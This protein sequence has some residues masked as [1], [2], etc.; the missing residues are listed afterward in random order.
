MLL[1]TMK[2]HNKVHTNTFGNIIQM[3]L[4]FTLSMGVLVRNGLV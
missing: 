3:A 2:N 1:S 4:G